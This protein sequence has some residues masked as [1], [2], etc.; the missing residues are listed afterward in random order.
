MEAALARFAHVGFDLDDTLCNDAGTSKHALRGVSNLISTSG[1]GLDN[2]PEQL[3]Q[4]DVGGGAALA[5]CTGAETSAAGER[6]NPE[7]G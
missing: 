2:H 3:E 4:F 6:D 7:C 5:L 1:T